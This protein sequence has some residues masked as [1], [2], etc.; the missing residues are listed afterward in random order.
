MTFIGGGGGDDPFQEFEKA[1]RLA[2]PNLQLKKEIGLAL[3]G[4][5]DRLSG[6]QRTYTE[7]LLNRSLPRNDLAGFR[8]IL[9]LWFLGI[10]DYGVMRRIMPAS[11]GMM[12]SYARFLAERS[13]SI[14]ARHEALAAAESLEFDQATKDYDEAQRLVKYGVLDQAISLLTRCRETLKGIKFFGHLA[15]AP[16][17]GDDAGLDAQKKDLLWKSA[18]L[19]LAK[20]KLERNRKLEDADSE[21]REF[22]DL[23]PSYVEVTDLDAYL[24]DLRIIPENESEVSLRDVRQ[25]SFEVLLMFRLHKYRQIVSL[26]SQL[27]HSLVVP[28]EATRKDLSE[29]FMLI[30]DAYLKLDFVYESEGFYQR[31]LELAPNDLGILSRMKKYYERRNDADKIREVDRSLSHVLTGGQL[32]P[33]PRMLAKDAVLEQSLLMAA[34]QKRI[35]VGIQLGLLP[36]NAKPLVGVYLNGRVVSEDYAAEPAIDLEL[37]TLEGLNRLEIRAENGPVGILKLS[38]SDVTAADT[39]GGAGP[40]EP[41]KLY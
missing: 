36:G 1:A 2:G 24:K 18:V 20:A 10:K 29:I 5:W 23:E 25:L 35:R 11:S 40:G 15:G 12:R 30:A 4:Q 14:A 8:E 16:A 13:L 37:E 33:A 39:A 38:V 32:L 21:L 3:L 27:Q 26:G 22:L 7:K 17:G 41:K 31:A 28:E 19:A 34:G 9:Y 6:S